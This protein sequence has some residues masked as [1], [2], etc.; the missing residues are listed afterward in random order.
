[1]PDA[2]ALAAVAEEY[3]Q[4]SESILDSFPKYRPPLDLFALDEKVAQLLTYTRKDTRLSNEQ[5]EEI[6]ELCAAGNLFV[7]RKDHPVYSRHIVK[8]LD[9]VLVDRNLKEAEVADI[10]IRALDLRLSEF[11][12][13]PVKTLF[14]QLLRDVQVLTEY[15][16]TDMHRLRLFVR[17]LHTGKFTLSRH[18]I[19]TMSVGLWL[20]VHPENENMKRKDLDQ[21]ALALLM[22]DVGMAKV[23]AFILN[24]SAPLKPEEKDKIPPHTVNGYKLMHKLDQSFDLMDRATLEHHERLDAS[25]YP[26]H[27]RI[28]SSFGRLTAVADAFSAM[29]QE[30]TYA[31]AKTPVDAARELADGKTRFDLS[32]SGKILASLMNDSFGKVQ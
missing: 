20:F 8:Q 11:F 14:E 23:P 21:A 6:R 3:Y 22:H 15:L 19:N 27:S 2:D 17:R 29:I 12:E 9:L 18:C 26:Q 5:V 1:M 24:K 16:W 13:Q 4:I 25:G 32:F 30:R 7:S 10:C 31:E 28:I